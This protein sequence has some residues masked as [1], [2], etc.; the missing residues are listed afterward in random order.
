SPNSSGF[1]PRYWSGLGSAPVHR[2]WARSSRDLLLS[3]AG[4][5][6]PGGLERLEVSDLL[7][8]LLLVLLA[9]LGRGDRHDVF[10]PIGQ[11]HDAALEDVALHFGPPGREVRQRHRL[12][13]TRRL[14]H[15]HQITS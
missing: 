12:H 4:V 7:R 15:A 10:T 5:G 6:H 8:P 13:N 14:A 9:R 11:V 2:S 1:P 3:G